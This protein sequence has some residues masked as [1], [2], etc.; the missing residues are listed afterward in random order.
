LEQKFYS[1]FSST[2]YA[3]HRMESHFLSL[4]FAC[5]G[6]CRDSAFVRYSFQFFISS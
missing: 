6:L 4:A 1:S 2:L 3:K 5:A